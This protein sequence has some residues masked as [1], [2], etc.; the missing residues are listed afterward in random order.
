[1]D[2]KINT[3]SVYLM[4]TQL[5]TFERHSYLN[6]FSI[7]NVYISLLETFL[8]QTRLPSN[9]AQENYPFNPFFI[10]LKNSLTSLV[11]FLVKAHTKFFNENDEQ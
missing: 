11:N 8:T 2:S 6:Y 7:Y 9:F 5:E 10:T 1:M 4:I 3:S